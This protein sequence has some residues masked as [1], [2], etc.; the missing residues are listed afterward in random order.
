VTLVL[1]LV[2]FARSLLSSGRFGPVFSEADAASAGPLQ[3][4]GRIFQ[5]HGRP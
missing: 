5:A 4:A 3:V 2:H 1:A